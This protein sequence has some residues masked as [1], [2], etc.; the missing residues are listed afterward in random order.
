MT[1][2]AVSTIPR[3]KLSSGGSSNV[4]AWNIELYCSEC[5]L[6]E[7]CT[8]RG[9]IRAFDHD[10]FLNLSNAM[11]E[12]EKKKIVPGLNKFC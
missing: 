2:T 11:G 4:D 5:I 9:G 1:T 8:Q 6:L 12:G 7:A 3:Y 10:K